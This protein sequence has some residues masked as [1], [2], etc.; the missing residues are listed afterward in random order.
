MT[1]SNEEE[2]TIAELHAIATRALANG[3]DC[4]RALLSEQLKQEE[5]GEPPEIVP[6]P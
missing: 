5:L 6:E 4:A 2:H 3:D 1:E